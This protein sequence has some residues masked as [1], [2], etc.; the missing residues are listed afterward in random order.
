MSAMTD[1]D[2]ARIYNE[3]NDI[4]LG[5]RPTITTARIFK[6]MRACFDIV[7]AQRMPN[8]TVEVRG[9]KDETSPEKT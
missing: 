7:P 5:K 3:A 2:L 9:L 4:P 1:A 6:A 8:L